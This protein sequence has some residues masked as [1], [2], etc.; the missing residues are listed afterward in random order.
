MQR[1]FFIQKRPNPL[2]SVL[3]LRGI[4]LQ[5]FNRSMDEF[6]MKVDQQVSH[7]QVIEK[8]AG[9]GMGVVYK[10]RDVKLDR[11][12]ALKFLPHHL[13]SEEHEIRF[14]QEAK[15]ASAL[16]HPNICTIYEI[17]KTSDGQ[18]FIAMGFYEGDTL[19]KKLSQS[20]ISIQEALHIALQITRGLS[21]AH[22][23]GVI[24]RDIKPAN[25]IIT[26]EGVVKIVDFGLA[27]FVDDTRITHT[28]IAVGTLQYMSPEQ[29][30]GKQ[31][32]HRTDIWSVG[33]LLYEMMSGNLPFSSTSE[34]GVIQSIINEEPTPIRN[35]LPNIPETLDKII[36]KTLS[37]PIQDRYVLMQQL[38]H[39]LEEINFQS[40][41]LSSARTIAS[42]ISKPTS[43]SKAAEKRQLA[44]VVSRLS[45]YFELVEELAPGKME[46]FIN[47]VHE[48]TTHIAGKHAAIV[49]KFTGEEIVTVFG[50]PASQEDDFVRAIRFAIEARGEIENLAASLD[51]RLSVGFHSGISGGSVVT[52]WIGS[53]DQ[54]YH[55]SGPPVQIAM[56]LSAE[57]TINEILVS[58]ECLRLI[59][60]Y[61]ET[62][63]CNPIKL[64][65]K[66]EIVP[67]CVLKESGLQ[68]RLEAS[69]KVG[70]TP[71][72]G[73]EKELNQ[74]KSTFENVLQEEGHL[75]TILGEAGIGKSRL[76]FEF[77]EFLNSKS[78]KVVQGRA[79]SFG[80][81]LAYFPFIDALR[82]LLIA[83]S[84]DSNSSSEK[85]LVSRIEKIDPG[86]SEFIPIY[87][88][89]LSVP[90]EDYTLPK[91]LA[92]EDLRLAI[93][94]ALLGIFTCSAKSEPLV[95][96]FEDWQSAD[97]TSDDVLKQIVESLLNFPIMLL[98]TSRPEKSFSFG[99]LSQQTSMRLGPL[100]GSSSKA[101]IQSIIQANTVPEN[102]VKTIHE[103]TGG[104]PFFLE[105]LCHSLLESGKILIQSGVAVLADAWE[106]IRLPETVEAVIR[107]RL[108]RLS[109]ADR[110]VLR[111]ASVTGREFSRVV[112]QQ[113]I[114]D[115][116]QLIRS[117]ESLKSIGLIQ[118]MTVVPE[119]TYKF[120]HALTRQVVYESILPHQRKLLHNSVADS[121][122]KLHPGRKEENS[123]LLAHHYSQSEDWK[124]AAKYG[125]QSAQKISRLGQFS[126]ALDLLQKSHSWL[127]K[128]PPDDDSIDTLIEILLKQER[129]CET[130]GNRAKQQEIINEL[131][132]TLFRRTDQPRIVEVYCRQSDLYTI[133]G[134]YDDAEHIVIEALRI[135]QELNDLEAEKKALRSMGFIRWHQE[136]YDDAVSVLEEALSIGSKTGHSQEVA[137][138]LTSL[139]NILRHQGKFE[140]A[141]NCLKQALQIYELQ[142]DPAKQCLTLYTI[143]AVH[144]Q[145]G[146]D[147]KFLEYMERG[148]DVGT[149]S[150]L[151]IQLTWN[152]LGFAKFHQQHRN[153]EKSLSYY[154]DA[155]ELGK[156]TRYAE[157]IMLALRGLTEV[158][159]AQG[160]EDEALLYLK[161][162]VNFLHDQ[163]DYPTEAE[164]RKTIA[165]IEERR[166]NLSEAVKNW[167]ALRDL[168]SRL[169]DDDGELEALESLARLC[170]VQDSFPQQALEFY[171]E[172]ILI[173]QKKGDRS[174]EGILLNS[175]A[176]LEWS[177]A[178]YRSALQYYRRALNIFQELHDKT[179]EGVI[180]NSLGV[181]FSR[182]GEFD[183]ASKCL[184]K[185][186][187]TNQQTGQRLLEAHSWAALGEVFQ[188]LGK[189]KES[190]EY[191]ETSL[192]IRVETK[193]RKGEGWMVYEL[194]RVY[195]LQKE[196]SKAK[197]LLSQATAI[198]SECSDGKLKDACKTLQSSLKNN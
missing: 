168:R 117:L 114:Q 85:V 43:P 181:T 11:F 154:K 33:V 165:S 12:V 4:S 135:S 89:L 147:E 115:H 106:N 100:N 22:E 124:K 83:R 74:L 29:V 113:S 120:K 13:D 130:L 143:A 136:R 24:H 167:N 82:D 69:E 172:A 174:K 107:T 98:I 70:F 102:L 26:H 186:V 160:K 80:T 104:N 88:H 122:E 108:D 145:L 109:S 137:G 65:G 68:S 6:H 97:E 16:D 170:R 128:I 95:L 149:K 57:A 3:I 132:K 123:E 41:Q 50:L 58:S 121:L 158:L 46:T 112:L 171:Q 21:K 28:G 144:S 180:W 62:Q 8:L 9:G 148:Y 94:E 198:A 192:Q 187:E 163:G 111:V 166:S 131:L 191:Y 159:I 173:A 156:K 71:Y 196:L 36:R 72:E 190:K 35:Y 179:Q 10:A 176:V 193:D 52:E 47:Q 177:R 19:K 169:N 116:S 118:Q 86:L 55:I 59:G 178:D 37:K 53:N 103:H 184:N 90:T 175:I 34:V 93:Q 142:A 48:M 75:V 81:Q 138:D 152:L 63:A 105:E 141:L 125:L 39:E 110:E 183:D 133:V 23:H 188:R 27:R 67:Y 127:T 151:C 129:L 14:I 38:A 84:N 32:D 77:R 87:L 7:Y 45:N 54:Q 146:D 164:V 99:N 40:E 17:D 25:V 161:E 126:E 134:Q 51:D 31:I 76:L 91:H 185:G 92:G 64:Q 15:T 119:A 101:I 44:V 157:G 60:P 162:R 194:A 197:E 30:R 61:F 140:R 153:I 49:N 195:D 189:L 79:Q 150:R 20:R 139:G 66:K 78:T 5:C 2:G 1:I 56:R 155:L 18:V 96:F 73:R 182:L 42:P